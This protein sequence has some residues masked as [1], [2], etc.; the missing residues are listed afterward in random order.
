MKKTKFLFSQIILLLLAIL[1]S[2]SSKAQTIESDAYYRL[3]NSFLTTTRSLDTYVNASKTIFMGQTGNYKGQKWKFTAL[4]GNKYKITNHNFGDNVCLDVNKSSTKPFMGNWGNY[5]GQYWTLKP[6]SAGYYFIVDGYGRNLDTYNNAAKD[7]FVTDKGVASGQYWKIT[8]TGQVSTASTRTTTTAAAPIQYKEFTIESPYFVV[9]KDDDGS[10]TPAIFGSI[11]LRLRKNGVVEKNWNLF[12]RTDASGARVTARENNKISLPVA[13]PKFTINAADISK[14]DLKLDIELWDYD[15]SS[16]NDKL[17]KVSTYLNLAAVGSM[18]MEMSKILTGEGKVKVAVS[19]YQGVKTKE[20]LK[21]KIEDKSDKDASYIDM[22]LETVHIAVGDHVNGMAYNGRDIIVNFPHDNR[23]KGDLFW[24]NK[25]DGWEEMTF[26]MVNK[27]AGSD[28]FP[29]GMQASG[30]L[31]AVAENKYIRFFDF[32]AGPKSSVSEISSMKIEMPAGNKEV[33]GM[34]FNKSLN[35]YYLV[36]VGAVYA[37]RAGISPFINN[38]YNP[39]FQFVKITS[40]GGIPFGEA[41]LA[42][43]YDEANPLKLICLSLGTDKKSFEYK[44]TE[45][46][47]YTTGNSATIGTSFTTKT[48]SPPS[49]HDLTGS[50]ASFRWGGTADYNNGVLS[51]YAAPKR[52][53]NF[54]K[55]TSSDAVIWKIR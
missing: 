46:T 19:I 29:S 51:I 23:N 5:T 30:R 21:Y 53:D 38:V 55:P 22:D 45:I 41:G 33:V 39:S 17:G 14:Y 44:A 9:Q 20:S 40:S 1:I 54:W 32:G 6:A 12:S 15:A 48:L 28:R 25:A 2:N 31:L 4:G 7:L 34:T 36:T 52:L 42:L 8:K 47:L 27:T 24:W 11:A 49:G 43:L 3:T 26:D 50:G 18:P 35:R 13:N 37:S 10:T 16:S